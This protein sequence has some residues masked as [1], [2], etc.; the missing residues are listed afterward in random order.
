MRKAFAET[1]LQLAKQD[2][3]VIL[4]T[5]DLGF[6]V[7]DQFE[8]A[9]PD[10]FINVGICEQAMVDIAC[11]LAMEGY[12]P[13]CYSIASFMTG[14]AYEQIKLAAYQNLP[15]L[16]VGAGGGYCYSTAGSTHHAPDDLGLM[17]LIPNMVVTA[18][19]CPSEVTHLLRELVTLNTPSYMRIGRYGEPD[20]Q[21]VESYEGAAWKG[22]G[23][24]EWGYARYL[25][26]GTGGTIVTTG[27]M[28]IRAL[29]TIGPSIYQFHTIKPLDTATLAQL[30]EPILVVEEHSPYGGL[31]AAIMATGLKQN[32]VRVGPKD[33]FL[34]DCLS[35]EEFSK[36]NEM[37]VESIQRIVWE[38]VCEH[39]NQ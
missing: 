37:D 25:R 38:A 27:D 5:G 10:R 29:Q 22:T 21:S 7:F 4:L 24:C 19:G 12:R 9:Y 23:L 1:L 26:E 35:R 14:R 28:A 16:I 20:Y 2:E 33:A 17:S 36:Q 31:Y 11:G 39:Q 15:I 30:E 6:G 18:P 3:R 8:E 13:I 32:V 34:L